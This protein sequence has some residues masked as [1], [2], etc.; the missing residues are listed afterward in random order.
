ME[1]LPI[2]SGPELEK[3]TN[4][5]VKLLVNSLQDPYP[6]NTLL[7]QFLHMLIIKS[8]LNCAAQ[9]AVYMEM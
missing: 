4:G 6:D 5:K 3:Y 7:V 1:T 2:H 8:S 9:E